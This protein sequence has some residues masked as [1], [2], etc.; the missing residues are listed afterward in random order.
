MGSG[1]DLRA[2]IVHCLKSV[3]DHRKCQTDAM[4]ERNQSMIVRTNEIRKRDPIG[5]CEHR[6]SSGTFLGA[7]VVFLFQITVSA[8]EALAAE[9]EMRHAKIGSEEIDL[10][11]MKQQTPAFIEYQQ[12]I[13]QHLYARLKDAQKNL[14]QFVCPTFDFLCYC[15][16]FM[17]KMQI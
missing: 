1:S 15:L 10:E 8:Y 17:L 3:V 5:S 16:M 7:N 13:L 11:R 6:I 2:A 12:S 14:R 4:N 9:L